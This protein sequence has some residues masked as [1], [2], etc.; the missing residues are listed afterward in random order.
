VVNSFTYN[1]HI[2]IEN[3]NININNNNMN[4]HFEEL[5][6]NL[7]QYRNADFS[8]YNILRNLMNFLN[9]WINEFRAMIPVG[10]TLPGNWD[11]NLNFENIVYRLSNSVLFDN[12]NYRPD[13]VRW[14]LVIMMQVESRLMGMV[15][16]LNYI[17]NAP[18]LWRQNNMNVRGL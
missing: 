16:E 18:L 17:P 8:N 7:G 11:V 13:I 15:G 12:H 9:G 5:R 1:N 2:K 14:V 3:I 6:I 10:F 4:N